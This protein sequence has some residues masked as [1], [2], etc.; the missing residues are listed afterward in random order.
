MLLEQAGL[1]GSIEATDVDSSALNAARAGI[2]P[3]AAAVELPPV[4]ATRFLEPIVAR[5]Q[6]AYRVQAGLRARIRFSWHDLTSDA[7]PPG[8]QRF[9]LVSCCN[10]LIYLQPAAQAD[11]T[12][13]LLRATED[14]G[15]LCLGEAEWPLPLFAAT[16]QPLARRTRLFRVRA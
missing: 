10:V 14:K 2:Y 3:I 8:E 16:L 7:P 6:P 13:R 11:A 15:V 9:D 12:T 4:L 1:D 5:E